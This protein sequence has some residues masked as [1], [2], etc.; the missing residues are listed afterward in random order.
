MSRGVLVL[1][2][3]G[4]VAAA[5][6]WGSEVLIDSGSVT[7]FDA[8]ADTSG[9]IWA[10]IAYQ[11]S[12]VG[13]YY[14][15]DFGSTWHGRWAM[16]A[17]ASVR[18]LQLVSGQGDSS[19]FYLFMLQSGNGGDLWL[20]RIPYDSSQPGLMPVA[21]GPDTIDDFSVAIDRD[22]H[23]YLYC[24]YVNEHRAGRTGAFTRSLDYGLSWEPGTDWWNAWD[25]CISYTTGSTIHCAWRYALNGGE[26]HYS[27]NRH[28]GM[29]GYWSTYRVVSDSLAG[30]CFDPTVMQADSTPESKAAVWV[31]YTVGR[32]DTSVRDLEYSSSTDGGSNWTL[33]LPFGN[34]TTEEQQ[35]RLAADRSKPNDYVSLCYAAGSRQS[36]NEVAAYWTCANSSAPDGWLSPVKVSRFPLAGL[37]PRLVYVPHAPMRLPGVFYSQQTESGPWGVRFAAPW[38]ASSRL[39]A[40]VSQSPGPASWPNPS[41]G[42][43]NFSAAVTEPGHYTLAVYDAA[44]RLVTSLF[45]GRLEPGPQYWV[46]NRTF[47]SG[48]RMPAGTF[49]VRFKGPRSCFTRRLTLL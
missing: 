7:A 16:H 36:A 34:S 33:G 45:D 32:R 23:Y 28:Y 17:D 8:T 13:L 18:Q 37:A 48:R 22:A 47:P 30:Q 43:V 1:L 11:D 19:F 6:F 44:G 5:G 49:F 31:F 2:A 46:W 24:L 42:P 12:A 25:P 20:A 27:F 41:S 9:G 3:V 38:L 10:A 35:P 4:S 14:S 26:I 40:P 39:P 15:G 21:V 29:P